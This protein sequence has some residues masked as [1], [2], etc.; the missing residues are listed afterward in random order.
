MAGSLRRWL[1]LV[2]AM[3]RPVFGWNLSSWPWEEV[4]VGEEGAG[5]GPELL[6]LLLPDVCC[7]AQDSVFSVRM[8]PF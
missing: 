5:S 6:E 1:G 7:P 2:L 8:F 3:E 4:T